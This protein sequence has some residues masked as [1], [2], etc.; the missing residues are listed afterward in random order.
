MAFKCPYC[1]LMVRGMGKLN[2]A[3]YSVNYKSS[4]GTD[5]GSTASYEMFL[6][7]CHTVYNRLCNSNVSHAYTGMN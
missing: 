5:D 1:S 2:Y 4:G 6:C 7:M 3:K